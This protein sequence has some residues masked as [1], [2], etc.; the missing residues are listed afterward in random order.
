MNIIYLAC[1]RARLK[2]INDIVI[3]NDLFED[4]DL[5]CDMMD[6]N[7]EK[8]DFLIATPPCNYYSRSNFRRETSV[9]AQ[10]T[11]HLLSD[12]LKKF[13][14]SG[15]PFIIENVRNF[16]L[17]KKNGLFDFSCFV[18]FHG[19]HTYWTNIMVDFSHI[20]QT[21]DFRYIPGYG[22]VRLKSYVQGGDNVNNVF[23]YVINYYKFLHSL[24]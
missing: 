10:E 23:S 8:Y 20:P 14:L 2:N 9:Y 3:Y 19:R 16:P 15:K 17:F 21:F 11:K 12:I 6:V 7:L 13:L 1:G 5:K 22:C 4:C 18:Y 24:K